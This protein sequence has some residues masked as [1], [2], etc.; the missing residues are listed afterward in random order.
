VDSF[1]FDAVDVR[2]VTRMRDPVQRDFWH[3]RAVL[4]D[5]LLISVS[6]VTIRKKRECLQRGSV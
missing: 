6:L 4:L 5:V 2:D 1:S 3:V